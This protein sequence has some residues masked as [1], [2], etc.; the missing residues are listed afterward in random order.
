MD[1]GGVAAVSVAALDGTL[2]VT[3]FRAADAGTLTRAA[4]RRSCHLREGTRLTVTRGRVVPVAR[5]RPA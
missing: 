5:D 2:R 3:A 4:G 1:A